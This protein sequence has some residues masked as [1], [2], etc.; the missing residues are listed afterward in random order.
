MFENISLEAR[1]GVLHSQLLKTIDAFDKSDESTQSFVFI[2]IG[3]NMNEIKKNYGP[4]ED[5]PNNIKKVFA[6]FYFEEAKKAIAS[7]VGLGLGLHI[8]SI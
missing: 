2:T 1:G 8:F 7:D 5:I 6:K 3:H 4:L